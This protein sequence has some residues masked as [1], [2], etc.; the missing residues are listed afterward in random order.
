[1]SVL[2]VHEMGQQGD[3]VVRDGTRMLHIPKVLV[4]EALELVDG[5]LSRIV[6]PSPHRIAP[7]CKYYDA[8]GGCKLQHWKSQPYMEWKS[9]LVVDALAG[10]GL[11]VDV[12]PLIDAHGEGR[13]RVSLHV[14]Q[15]KGVWV[16]GFMGQKSH[17]LCAI[18]QCPVLAPA[19]EKAPAIAAAFGPSLGV[20]DVAI[21]VTSGG[22]DVAIKAERK[23]VPR[24]MEGLVALGRQHRLARLS[25]NGDVLVTLQQ[26]TV[27][28]GRAKVLL[29]V[30]S[31]LQAT[32]L[33]EEVLSSL[34]V[35]HL[36]GAK[37]V[38]DLFC[39]L[40]PFALRIAETSRVAAYDSDR[41]AIENL[42]LAV[43]NTMGLKPVHAEV[44][45][46]FKA[47]LI[48]ME[49][50]EH[51]AVVFDPPR[52]GADEQAREIAK[53][54][55]KRVVAVSCNAGTFARDAGILVKGGYTLK[56]VTPVD[57]FKYTAHVEIVA[58]FAR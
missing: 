28:V 35:K 37:H 39:G 50:K 10:H 1:V 7:F 4:G 12:A 15:Q 41:P 42:K 21:T 53:S 30:Q 31:F 45:N 34:V 17:D 25:V 52:A 22:L 11:V 5:Q 36:S 54:T 43:R 40:G 9:Q 56:N 24:R 19:L 3:G 18:D 44:R 2:R 29:P 23:A 49:L 16:A 38:A 55:V 6:L 48:A 13:R 26:P 32:D 51:D 14:R 33:G 46:L 20:C 58:L 57:Q 27:S 47:P 8:C